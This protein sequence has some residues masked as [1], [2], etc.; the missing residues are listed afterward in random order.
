LKDYIPGTVLP[1]HLSPF[2][3]SKEMGYLTSREKE[4]K[5]FKGEFVEESVEDSEDEIT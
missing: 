5:K 3:D 2:V 4:I 1:P